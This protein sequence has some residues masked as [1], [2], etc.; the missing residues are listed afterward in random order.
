MRQNEVL[1]RALEE[2][3]DYWLDSLLPFCGTQALIQKYPQFAE[4]FK[5]EFYFEF[6]IRFEDESNK[7][8]ISSWRLFK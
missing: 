3:R 2:L 4:R 6:G 5:L 1:N 8:V 7:D